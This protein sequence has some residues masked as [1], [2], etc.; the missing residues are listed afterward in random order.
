MMAVI[1]VYD[2]AGNV[3]E[4]HERAGEFKERL[5]WRYIHLRVVW[6]KS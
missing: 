4:T 1:R 5:A 6:E 3:T 2:A